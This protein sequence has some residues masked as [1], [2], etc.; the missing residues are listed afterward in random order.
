MR[1]GN[2]NLEKVD[3]FIEDVIK[4]VIKFVVIDDI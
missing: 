4:S 2:F 3:L 1:V